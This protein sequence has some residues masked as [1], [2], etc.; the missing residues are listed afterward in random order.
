MLRRER[1]DKLFQ[2]AKFIP[3]IQHAVVA[4]TFSQFFQ[5]SHIVERH[6]CFAAGLI[7]QHIAGNLVEKRNAIAYLPPVIDCISSG[8]RFSNDV[9]QIDMRW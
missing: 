9:V 5:I 2:S 6:D 1:C 4:D 7:N 3:C 8:Q